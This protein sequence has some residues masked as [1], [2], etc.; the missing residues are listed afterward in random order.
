M[1]YL[2]S[3]C[4]YCAREYNSRSGSCRKCHGN[5]PTAWALDKARA[6]FIA[7]PESDAAIEEFERRVMVALTNPPPAP[8]PGSGIVYR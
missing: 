7:Q 6:W 2:P 8:T 1:V 3:A 5:N 4:L